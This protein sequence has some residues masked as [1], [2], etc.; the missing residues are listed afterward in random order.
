MSKLFKMEEK[1]LTPQE[2]MALIESMIGKAR[3]RYSDNSFYF[4][5]WGWIVLTASLTHFYLLTYTTFEHP[6]IGWSLTVI[7]GI[8]SGIVGAKRSKNAEVKNYTDNMYGWLWLSLG[9][10][11]FTIIFN[12]ELIGWNTIPFI[13]LLAGVGTSVSGAM[14][15]FRPL[16]IG[17]VVF[18]I[19]TFVAFRQPENYQMLTMAIGIAAGYLI[20]GYIL[21]ANFKKHGV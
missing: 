13:L 14:M 19:L 20:P 16:Q 17:A 15:G 2:S 1:E 21:K 7:G 3:K 8:V 6:Y 11:M 12:G 5:F 10:A 9:M 4:L 18:W